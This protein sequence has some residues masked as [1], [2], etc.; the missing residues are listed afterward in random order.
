MI[1][2]DNSL[3]LIEDIRETLQEALSYYRT[4]IKKIRESKEKST[5]IITSETLRQE[6]V[7]LSLKIED[8]INKIDSIDLYLEEVHN[9]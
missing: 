1:T 5:D 2:N 7:K 4:E 6:E 3:I 8:I 9:N